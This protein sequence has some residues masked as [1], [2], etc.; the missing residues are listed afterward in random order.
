MQNDETAPEP[1]RSR[2]NVL[3]TFL[4]LAGHT[5]A[6]SPF[7]AASSSRRLQSSANTAE[8][9]PTRESKALMPEPHVLGAATSSAGS[10]TEGLPTIG[11][12]AI[13]PFLDSR[14]ESREIFRSGWG[15]VKE[16]E[17]LP[18]MS[19]AGPKSRAGQE[20]ALLRR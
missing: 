11:G 13:G 1:V 8:A 6:R 19:K 16:T 9:A 15:V 20:P 14:R 18:Q 7:C 4:Q 10:G 5:E 2:C 12:I 17:A 3:S